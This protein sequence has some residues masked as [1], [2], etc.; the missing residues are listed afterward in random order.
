MG[1]RRVPM[2]GS[3]EA[4]LQA[5]A[6]GFDCLLVA[7]PSVDPYHIL[8]RLIPLLKPSSNFVI[9]SKWLQP[10]AEALL[11]LQDS[12]Q[13]LNLQLQEGWL[14]EYQVLPLRT[15]PTM[16]MHGTGGYL[17]SGVSVGNNLPPKRA[18]QNGGAG[19]AATKRQRR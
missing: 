6:T 2:V 19:F 10:L 7:T 1:R 14:R 16:N 18:T 13:A 11:Q 4:L 3:T 9:Y 12:K 15:H 8:S 5:I 17:L